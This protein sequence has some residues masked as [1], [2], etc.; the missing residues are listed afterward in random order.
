MFIP[1]I[2]TATYRRHVTVINKNIVYTDTVLSL[3]DLGENIVL[4]TVRNIDEYN[5]EDCIKVIMEE[6]SDIVFNTVQYS[7]AEKKIYFYTD[8]SISTKKWD[9]RGTRIYEAISTKQQILEEIKRVLGEIHIVP[10]DCVTLYDVFCVIDSIKDRKNSVKERYDDVLTNMVKNH[11]SKSSSI[12]FDEFDYDT[13]TLIMRFSYSNFEYKSIQFVKEDG[14]LRIL[15][16]DSPWAMEVLECVG[17]TLSALYDEMLKFS[18]YNF[19]KSKEVKPINSN[20]MVDVDPRYGVDIFSRGIENTWIKDFEVTHRTYDDDNEYDVKCN[21]NI[22]MEAVKGKETELYK[23]IYVKICE[24][25]KSLG[26]DLTSLREKQLDDEF[27]RTHN[28]GPKNEQGENAQV[29]R[30]G[31]IRKIFNY[32]S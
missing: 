11:I 7:R 15:K 30:L 24:C 14:D 3:K 5:F 16:S 4:N 9:E 10:E 23:R 21:S 19:D 27:R 22:V 13:G 25:P 1:V 20:F 12:H 17:T 8:K 26:D 28:V 31:L 32:F 29:K 6:N 2:N 18:K